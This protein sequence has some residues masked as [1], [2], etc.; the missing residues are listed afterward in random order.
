[1]I[2]RGAARG[3]VRSSIFT[4]PLLRECGRVDAGFKS[5]QMSVVQPDT[6]CVLPRRADSL[7]QEEGQLEV[8]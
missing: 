4:S 3:I 5:V 7:A 1:M 6:C 2:A 8:L